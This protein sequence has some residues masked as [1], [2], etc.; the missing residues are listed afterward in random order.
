MAGSF[1][2]AFAVLVFSAANSAPRIVSSSSSSS[3]H[4]DESHH[5]VHEKSLEDLVMDLEADH[6]DVTW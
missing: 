4:L 1:L 6:D 3:R 5:L 2:I